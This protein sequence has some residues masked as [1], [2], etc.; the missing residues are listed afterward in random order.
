MKISNLIIKT[1]NTYLYSFKNKKIKII[2]PILGKLI[3]NNLINITNADFENIKE[4]CKLAELTYH[5]FEYYINKLNILKREGYFEE[6]DIEQILNQRITPEL[7]EYNL[8]NCNMVT[9]ET[10]ERCNL[11]CKY[12]G[13]G[14][15][16]NN[17]NKRSN[18]DIPIN[19]AITTLN[20]LNEYKSSL[21]NLSYNDEFKISFYGGEPLLNYKLISNTIGYIKNNN[22]FSKN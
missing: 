15:F 20:F 22:L 19:Y 13:Y 6:L 21:R 4:K 12:C 16:Y 7:L 17:Y 18:K 3:E 10:T 11:K 9:F 2:H 1:T 5:D 8:A 14:E